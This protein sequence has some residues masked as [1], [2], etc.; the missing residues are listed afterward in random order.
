MKKYTSAI[1]CIFML[2]NTGAFAASDNLLEFEKSNVPV[3]NTVP[4]LKERKDG[5]FSL[6]TIM[7]SFLNTRTRQ[8]EEEGNLNDGQK[9]RNAFVDATKKF[10]QGNVVV[11]YDEF[12]TLLNDIN[13]DYALLIF[14]KSMYEI[15][16]FSI[17]TKSLE[18]IRHKNLLQDMIEQMKKCYLPSFVLDKNEEIYLAKAYS[19][20]RYDNS[21]QETAFDLN[22]NEA[23]MQKSDYANY[24]LSRAMD[25]SRQYRQALLFINKA[26]F[27]SPNNISYINFKVKIL[28][29]L[30]KNKEA[31]RLI[32]ETQQNYPDE[33][34]F[35]NSFMIQKEVILSNLAKDEKEKKYHLAMK[36]L[37]EGNYQKT[38]EECQNILSFDKKNYKVLS[39]LALCQFITG[40][41]EEAK[42]NYLAS[43]EINK[44]YPMTLSGLGDVKFCEYDMEGAVKYY[45]KALSQ[46]PNDQTSALK[47][48]LIY[49]NDS[50]YSKDL[51]NLEK[52]LAKMNPEPF[53]SY[54]SIAATIASDNKNL[55]KEYI[56]RA[57]AI[58][59]LYENGWAAFLNF[60]LANNNLES[61]KNFLYM[62]SFSNSTN[63]MYFYLNALYDIKT[64]NTNSAIVNLK[65]CLSLKPDFKDANKKLLRLIP[66][67]ITPQENVQKPMPSNFIDQPVL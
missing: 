46:E 7:D 18:K 13:S 37:L 16:F 50:K 6:S 26:S 59:P 64:G 48:A 24:I 52:K 54:Y 49:K 53:L 56:R 67:E 65:N 21:A 28:A 38:L 29:S 23:L 15:G 45:K 60:E 4:K 27:M 17:G 14:A 61:A 57:S 62:I 30:Q 66:N 12:E 35:K 40:D 11:A 10:N 58:N 42:K 5:I 34:I 32:E 55:K 25:E 39:L 63:Y 19:S 47:L 9:Q 22:K 51:K 41:K 31:L 20:I 43:Y 33:N 3:S 36:T 44:D 2:C 8:D 1:L